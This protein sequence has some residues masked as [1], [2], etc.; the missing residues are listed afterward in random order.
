MQRVQKCASCGF[1]VSDGRTL[2]LDCERKDSQKRDFEKKQLEKSQLELD[3]R[4]DPDAASVGAPPAPEEFVPAFLANAKPVRESWMSNHV[5][6][7]AIVVLILG[8]L[9][10]IVV[11]R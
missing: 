7:L 5:N 2:C 9:V 4:V 8:V 3:A 1:P 11:F 10:T 6:L